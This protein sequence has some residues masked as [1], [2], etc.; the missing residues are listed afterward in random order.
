MLNFDTMCSWV[1]ISDLHYVL[2]YIV[3]LR[4]DC[5]IVVVFNYLELQACFGV[6]GF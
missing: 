5:L 3:E 1:R 4:V 6:L 2:D